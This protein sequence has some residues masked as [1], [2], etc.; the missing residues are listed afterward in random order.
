MDKE[1]MTCLPKLFLISLAQ[2]LQD[3]HSRVSNRD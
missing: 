1:I 3:K 2:S